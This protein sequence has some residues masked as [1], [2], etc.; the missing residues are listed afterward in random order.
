M[1]T[2]F[3]LHFIVISCAHYVVGVSVFLADVLVVSGVASSVCLFRRRTFTHDMRIR[4]LKKQL[5]VWLIRKWMVHAKFGVLFSFSF[6]GTNQK[7][8]YIYE[9]Q[10]NE[11]EEEEEVD[12]KKTIARWYCFWITQK[13]RAQYI[14]FSLN[15]LLTSSLTMKIHC[16]WNSF[17]YDVV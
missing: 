3:Q 4:L 13:T 16:C 7:K 5:F 1:R 10:T 9:E 8:K 11:E 12:E 15:T 2:P 6:S 17:P 14:F